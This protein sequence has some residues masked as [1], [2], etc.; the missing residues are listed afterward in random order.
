MTDPTLGRDCAAAAR[1]AVG[2][3]ARASLAGDHV[4]AA[5]QAEFAAGMLRAAAF[6]ERRGALGKSGKGEGAG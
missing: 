6:Y 2:E 5:R 3:A 4:E 1:E